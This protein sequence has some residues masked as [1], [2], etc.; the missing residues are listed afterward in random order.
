[1][2][3]RQSMLTIKFS[4]IHDQR[5]LV[6]IGILWYLL[7]KTATNLDPRWIGATQSSIN[8]N[9]SLW[10]KRR[11]ASIQLTRWTLIY[12]VIEIRVQISE[13][14]FIKYKNVTIWNDYY[15]YVK[16]DT[17]IGLGEYQWNE[18]TLTLIWLNL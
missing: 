6:F 12:K 10:H 17:N 18:T 5:I 11:S 16:Y 1:M 14:K 3:H 4:H 15:Q 8:T 13:M 2:Y 7:V 9:P